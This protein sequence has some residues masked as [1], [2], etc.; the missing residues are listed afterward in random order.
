MQFQRMEEQELFRAQQG[1]WLLEEFSVGSL[2]QAKKYT[3][4]ESSIM[5]NEKRS[6]HVSLK[7]SL[8]SWVESPSKKLIKSQLEMW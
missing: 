2:K 3:F 6:L 4:L 7:I 8:F 1:L 5:M